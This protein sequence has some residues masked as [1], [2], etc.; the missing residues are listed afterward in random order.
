[1]D[2]DSPRGCSAAAM[3]IPMSMATFGGVAL[4]DVGKAPGL[5]DLIRQLGGSVGMAL[6]VH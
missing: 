6:D 5:Y 4:H 3:F 2:A 1:M